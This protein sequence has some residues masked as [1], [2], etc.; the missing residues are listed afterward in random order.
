MS[1]SISPASA[2]DRFGTSEAVMREL[3]ELEAPPQRDSDTQPKLAGG[4]LGVIMTLASLLLLRGFAS[5]DAGA[6]Y[7][8]SK[9]D[10]AA[11]AS[12][13]LSQL[14]PV[15]TDPSNAVAD[16]PA[17]AELG[18][19][20]FADPRLSRNGAVS[21]ASCHAPDRQF[22]DGRPVSQGVGTGKR[23]TMPVAA[24]AYNPWLFWDGRKDSLWS[25]ALGPLEDGVEH[26]G[27]RARYARL[28]QNDYVREYESVFGSLP[29]LQGVP[30]DASP[31]GSP[32]ERDAWSHGLD[33]AGGA[34]RRGLPEYPVRPHR[35][36][37]D[38]ASSP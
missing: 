28:L 21:C 7:P 31:L 29:D 5:A 34:R 17:A 33:R 19:R 4:I 6:T 32:A 36:A 26:G 38:T 18:K 20:L 27:N 22:Q 1:S 3:P 15:P 14:P 16:N 10:Q 8:W 9:E 23:R 11:L 12:M 2:A 13:A 25:Q 30:D 37:L 35:G 24:T